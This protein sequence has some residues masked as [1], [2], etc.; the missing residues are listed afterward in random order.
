MGLFHK[1]EKIHGD[2]QMSSSTSRLVLNKK[3][4]PV[5]YALFK[6]FDLKS[7]LNATVINN[8]PLYH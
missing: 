4:L 5:F 2:K 1:K 8:F 7:T 6:P 3:K